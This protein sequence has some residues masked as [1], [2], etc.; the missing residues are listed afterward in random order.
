MC[1]GI[2]GLRTAINLYRRGWDNHRLL[3]FFFFKLIMQINFLSKN[4][5]VG[6]T[7]NTLS[8]VST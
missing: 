5:N 1:V 2:G 6:F 8:Q 3:P 4:N 7:T